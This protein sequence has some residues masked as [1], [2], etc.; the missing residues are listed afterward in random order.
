MKFF[1]LLLV[2]FITAS[3][4][5]TTAPKTPAPAPPRVTPSHPPA[6]PPATISIGD[7][8]PNRV[9]ATIGDETITAAQFEELVNCLDPQYQAQARG[10]AK[11]KFM[12][13][14]VLVRVLTKYALQKHIDQ[15]ETARL[16]VEFDQNRALANLAR[17]AMEENSNI[18]SDTLHKYY[19]EHKVEYEQ[20]EAHHI[21]IRFKGS[22]I[23]MKEGQKDL[24]DE[25]ALAKAQ[26]LMKRL[27]AGED[28]A[29]LATDESDDAGSAARGGDL[30]AFK[31]AQMVAPFEAVAFSLPAGQI[32]DPVKTQY[33]YHIIRVDKVEFKTFEQV[34]PE[35]EATLRPLL[36]KKKL[37]DLREQA[38]VKLD[39]AFFGPAASTTPVVTQVK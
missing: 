39:D 20:V 28:F 15:T 33:G 27:K 13:Q 4:A 25:Q 22:P 3:F 6:A 16:L 7:T 21:L 10:P 23:P 18:D 38:H 19:D 26:D 1:G 29:K 24:T 17:K 12:E 32:S 8:D 37:D 11:R 5:Q 30:G 36:L 14:M 34:R 9:V 35:I 31:H 2:A